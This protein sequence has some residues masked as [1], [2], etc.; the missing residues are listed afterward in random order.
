MVIQ[1]LNWGRTTQKWI[2]KGVFFSVTRFKN[3][4]KQTLWFIA[5]LFL[6]GYSFATHYLIFRL[7]RITMLEKNGKACN[8]KKKAFWRRIW[9]LLGIIVSNP[10]TAALFFKVQKSISTDRR[11]Y[12]IWLSLCT[13]MPLRSCFLAPFI[14]DCMRALLVYEWLYPQY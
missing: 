12:I 2:K 14:L 13:L 5:S 3:L 4:I 7:L 1:T 8:K 9:T 10:T 11:I 6:E